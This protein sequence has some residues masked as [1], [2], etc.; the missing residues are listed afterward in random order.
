[1]RN[2]ISPNQAAF[3]KGRNITDN[4]I[5]VRELIHSFGSTNYRDKSFI[6]KANVNKAFDTVQWSFVFA[7]TQ[8]VNIPTKIINLVRNCLRDSQITI[9]INGKGDGFIKPN[10][11]LRQGCPLSPYLFI[12][13]MEFLT[14]QFEQ[15]RLLGSIKGIQVARLA[16][17][18]THALYADDLIIMGEAARGEVRC[19]QGLL[20]N[21]ADHSGLTINPDKSALWF[22]DA[23]EEQDRQEVMQEL[24]AK[25][26][27]ESDKYLG[28]YITHGR[29]D[30]DL[31][32]NLLVEKFYNKLAGWK[33][34]FLSFAGRL[35]LIKS[36]LISVPV[37]FM[38]IAK[39]PAKTV[40]ELTKVM[41]KFLWGE[42]D[43]D[44]Y[45]SLIAWNKICVP[46]E[47]GGLGIRDVASF[48][49]AL[50]LKI[51]WQVASNQDRQLW[52]QILRAKYFPKGGFWGV[53]G[54]A[55]K[56]RL[57]KDIQELKP[58][59]KDQ[60]QWE[61][62]TGETVQAM[63]QPWYEEWEIQTILTNDQR[64]ATVAT[65]YNHSTGTWNREEITELMGPLALSR[66]ENTASKPKEQSLLPD[67]LIWSES[68]SGQYTAKQG[69]ELLTEMGNTTR[70][71]EETAKRAWKRMWSWK[72]I[73]PRIKTFIW[74]GIHNGVPT[75]ATLHNRIRTISPL[76]QRC[77]NEN[78]FLM[79]LLFFCD[80]SRATWFCSEFPLIIEHLPLN[81]PAAILYI[82][83]NLS[84]EQI[85]A[86]C[87][88]MW[89][90]WKA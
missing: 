78:K 24:A 13:S 85:I 64:K 46:I 58:V 56:S 19:I 74:K 10:R 15:A 2:I 7:A 22:S 3:L 47:D 4:I 27:E 14:K 28:V 34:N 12:L 66:I 6:L 68:K 73:I 71:Y 20:N 53:N 45:L 8:A 55:G 41:R 57:M 81:F 29:T 65:I 87:N 60:L 38:T 32:H 9:R 83:E 1:M 86:V 25:M 54:T 76:C 77:A 89:C 50:L 62:G 5:L 42:T 90:L 43:K 26:A 61:I 36:V 18:I 44:R 23:C 21:F 40:K 31:T 67:R 16:P 63:N 69:Y 88:L 49:K 37:Y 80:L 79:H 48:N 82:T 39:L 33:A 84:E 35:T 70:V 52:V 30:Q 75:A 59:I 17:T 11:G 51:V 72:G